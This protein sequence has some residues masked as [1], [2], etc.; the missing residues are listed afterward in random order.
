MHAQWKGRGHRATAAASSLRLP[1]TVALDVPLPYNCST[2]GGVVTYMLQRLPLR[3][4]L[5]RGI[6]LSLARFRAPLHGATRF[7]LPHS[8]TR[9]AARKHALG[10]HHKSEL[11]FHFVN[12]RPRSPY[13][14]P[15]T[16]FVQISH[17]CSTTARLLPRTSPL[18]TWT[19]PSASLNWS[20]SLVSHHQPPSIGA[21]RSADQHRLNLV[22]FM[23]KASSF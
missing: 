11:C 19:S 18:R 4:P 14:V 15:A 3:A 10:R 21:H 1:S 5:S 6:L 13:F 9:V 23:Q 22:L 17:A 2:F 12:R 7:P 8:R 20:P 16:L